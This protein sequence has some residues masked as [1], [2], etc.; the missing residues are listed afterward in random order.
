VD[1]SSITGDKWIPEKRAAAAEGPGREI[2]AESNW[3]RLAVKE[4]SLHA[5]DHVDLTGKKEEQK[6]RRKYM[7]SSKRRLYGKV[8]S[9]LTEA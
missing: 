8:A 7:A 3:L 4:D 5:A 2:S 6:I 1:S 9:C